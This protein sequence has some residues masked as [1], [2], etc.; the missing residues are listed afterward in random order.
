ALAG[1]VNVAPEGWLTPTER[2]ALDPVP[3]VRLPE[4]VAVAIANWRW[5]LGLAPTAPGILAYARHPWVVATDRL[6]ATGWSAEYSNEEAY[7]AGHEA[8]AIESISPRRRQELAMGVV[9][10]LVAGSAVGVVALV[11]RRRRRNA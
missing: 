6:T 4:R 3:R 1:P 10:A 5:R 8:R 7:V 9:G 11:R 2:L